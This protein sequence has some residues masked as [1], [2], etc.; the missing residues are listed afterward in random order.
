MPIPWNVELHHGR[1]GVRALRQSDAL[2]WDHLRRSSADWLGPWDASLP[3]EGG[4]PTTSY[5]HMI[6]VLR[7]RAKRGEVM[8]FV[9]TWDGVMVGQVSVSSITWGAARAASIGYWVAVDYAGRRITPTAVALVCDL[10]F[11]RMLLHRVDIAIRPENH[12]SL[13]VVRRLGF[14]EVGLAPRYLHIAGEWADHR[15][16]QLLSEDVGGRV[17]DRIGESHQ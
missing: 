16:F 10:L 14:T 15:L 2:R 6:S 9:T 7:K 11:E 17:I 4:Q 3:P 12:P 1:V 8:P 5:R 13:A